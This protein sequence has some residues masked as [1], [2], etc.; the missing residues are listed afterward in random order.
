MPSPA[1][2]FVVTLVAAVTFALGAAP[3]GAIETEDFTA[4]AAAPTISLTT[5]A[6]STDTDTAPLAPISS[7]LAESETTRSSAAHGFD[8]TAA[9]AAAT[10]EIGTSRATGWGAPGECIVSAQRWI[11]AGGGAWTGGG[12]P[13]SNYAGALRLSPTEAQPGDVI[14]YEHLQFPTSWVSG[15]H[16]VLVTGVNDDG[17]YKIIESNNPTGSGYVQADDSWVPKP[18]AGFQAVAWRF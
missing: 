2:P 4:A 7:V 8:V 5:Q 6:L 9:I 16:T 11:R 14:Q 15:V 13:V 1:K 18:P 3:A 17:T 12:D 10:A